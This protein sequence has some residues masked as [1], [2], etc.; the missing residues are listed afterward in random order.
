MQYAEFTRP[1][2][3]VR[4]IAKPTREIQAEADDENV[5]E[6]PVYFQLLLDGMRDV[7]RE[8]FPPARS[9]VN[10]LTRGQSPSRQ[11]RDPTPRY[12]GFHHPPLG[13]AILRSLFDSG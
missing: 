5:I 1:K 12:P 8:Y 10:Q 11:P 13:G 3:A 2:K 9:R 6:N 4:I 7:M